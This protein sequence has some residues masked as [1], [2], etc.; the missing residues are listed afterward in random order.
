MTGLQSRVSE[1]A[2]AAFT[3]LGALMI[4][5]GIFTFLIPG[6]GWG[7][8]LAFILGGGI[9]LARRSQLNPVATPTRT[10]ITL[11]FLKPLLFVAAALFVIWWLDGLLSWALV[12]FL[13]YMALRSVKS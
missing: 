4:A 12:A 9:F 2:K 10:K 1:V 3:G 8:G 7:L 5:L 11:D 6:I 13:A